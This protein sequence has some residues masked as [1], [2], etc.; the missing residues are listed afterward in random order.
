MTTIPIHAGGHVY[1]AHVGRGILR[2]GDVFASFRGRRAAIICD[3]NTRAV[4]D[5]ALEHDD[6]VVIEIAAGEGSKSLA[7]IGEICDRMIAAGL[8]RSAFVI[9]VGGG[10]V[11]DISGFVAAVFLRG[12]P[13]VQVPTTLLAMVDSSIGGKTGVNTVAGKNLIGAIHQPSLIVADLDTL[14]SLPAREFDQGFA[15]IIKHGI[16]RDA[17]MLA[18]LRAF[19]RGTL[20]ALVARN[21]GI[22]AAI[23]AADE[24]ETTGERA[25]LNF[26][27]TVGHAIE[28][29]AGYGQMLHG[30]AVSLGIVAACNL[31]VKRAGL[32]AHHR[33]AIVE[34]LAAF[35]LPTRLPDGISRDEVLAAIKV[36][37]KFDAGTVRVVVTPEPGK[38]YL[39]TD[40][41]FDDL[42]EAVMQL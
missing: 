4:V 26:G 31:S 34:L 18:A 7:Q 28:R 25:L 40:V 8:G 6:A 37:K 38:A 15:E 33:D 23:V 29:A 16:I 39:S 19:D 17:E 2:E 32:A 9:G 10:V 42:R 21:I 35:R 22:K 41:T 20:E 14:D 13:H 30:E 36:D 12:I 24:R 5:G 1:K 3:R 11:G 27:H